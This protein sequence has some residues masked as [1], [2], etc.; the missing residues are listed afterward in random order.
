MYL[1]IINTVY[2]AV[3]TFLVVKILNF[4]EYHFLKE[5]KMEKRSKNIMWGLVFITFVPSVY[6]GYVMIKK[7]AFEHEANLF[8]TSEAIFPNNFLLDKNISYENKEIKLTYG[9][10]KL[11]DSDLSKLQVKAAEYGLD[12]VKII[13][14]QGFNFVTSTSSD[15]SKGILNEE[16]SDINKEN[17]SKMIAIQDSLASENKL[18]AQVFK[19]L[20]VQNPKISGLSV[21][22]LT[23]QRDSTV[24]NAR[25]IFVETDQSLEAKQQ[26]A[27]KKWLRVRVNADSAKVIF[28][29]KRSD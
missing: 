21:S 17:I 26:E 24:Q 28:K 5:E 2:I 12:K 11:E 16:S 25:L 22:T 15:Q 7:N 9:G 18:S 29:S 14:K 27:I 3:S 6:F 1:Y 19:E 20:K 13:V 23:I 4:P 8:I 10:Q